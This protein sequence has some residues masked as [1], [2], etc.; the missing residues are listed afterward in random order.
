[1]IRPPTRTTRTSTLLH[2]T[3]LFRSNPDVFYALLHQAPSRSQSLKRLCS[4]YFVLIVECAIHSA[5]HSLS[6][7]RRDPPPAARRSEE[8]TSELQ[9]LMSISYAVFCLKRK[10]LNYSILMSVAHMKST[11][12]NTD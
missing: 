8:H 3:T 5:F 9:S 6:A 7:G 1:M 4:S 12:L 10:R 2:Y 11:E